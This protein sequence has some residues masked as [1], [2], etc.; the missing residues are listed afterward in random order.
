MLS[1]VTGSLG[2]GVCAIDGTGRITYMNPAGARMLGWSDEPGS[3]GELRDGIPASR[4]DPPRFLLD[5]AM[6]A[7]AL[8][9]N[10]VTDDI[11]VE[12]ADGSQLRVTLTASPMAGAAQPSAAVVVFRDTSDRKAFEEQL[13][14]HAFQDPLTRLANRR[15]LLDHLDHALLQAGRSESRVALL[16]GDLDRFKVVNDQLGHQLGDEFLRAVAERLRRAVRPGDTLS[17]FGGDEF[18]VVLEGIASADDALQVAE[19]ILDSLRHPVE[20]SGGHEVIATMSIG[21][22]LSHPQGSTR[23]DLLHDADVAMYRAKERG[24]GGASIMYDRELMGGRAA[25]AAPDLDAALHD[26]VR[27]GELEVH[28]QPMVSLADQRVVGAEALIRWD[29]PQHGILGPAQFMELAE[30]NGSIV[31]IGRAVL[32]Q[33]CRRA[34]LWQERLGVRLQ[35]G[36]NLSPR[37]FQQ[38]GLE[39]HVGRILS[40]T[41]LEPSLLCL[42]IT[43][44]LVMYDV[45]QTSSILSGLRA[46]GV[47]LA[48]DDFGTGHSSL[49]YLA[50]FPFDV[51]KI[52]HSFIRDIDHDPVKAAIV[53]AVIALSRAVGTTTVVE[54]VETLS[55]LEQVQQLGCDVAQGFYFSRPLPAGTFEELLAT[56]PADDLRIFRWELLSS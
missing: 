31:Q 6:R 5:P 55:E 11:R 8:V 10:V 4:N 25:Q 24:R 37:E 7:M 43:E 36:V 54:G 44:G 17:R 47:R 48:I 34:R 53:S 1:Q 46:L 23:D 42:E 41:G 2:E 40:D 9:Q 14:Q 19:R 27:R 20:L 56:S 29:H 51:I 45:E 50:R 35:I 16:F 15:L 39:E 52:D 18:V 38:P 30:G 49:G 32:E 21:M 13:A 12:R 3:G 22:A 26:L 28:F 33:A